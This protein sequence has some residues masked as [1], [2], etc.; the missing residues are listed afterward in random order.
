MNN[1]A[2]GFYFLLLSFKSVHVETYKNFTPYVQTSYTLRYCWSFLAADAEQS[3]AERC[4]PIEAILVL[5]HVNTDSHVSKKYE[6]SK[7]WGAS[8]KRKKKNI[9]ICLKDV[10]RSRKVSKLEKAI[11]HGAWHSLL[12]MQYLC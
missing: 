6:I 2:R 10:K 3:E 7:I 4:V 12:W 11:G 5:F 8:L 9:Y 1:K